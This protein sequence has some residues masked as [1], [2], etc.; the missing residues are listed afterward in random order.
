MCDQTIDRAFELAL[1]HALKSLFVLPD[2][3]RADRLELKQGPPDNERSLG[4]WCEGSAVQHGRGK[5]FEY[6]ME[7]PD[8]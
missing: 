2:G 6:L 1:E 8:A 7:S 5:F 3:E 4:G